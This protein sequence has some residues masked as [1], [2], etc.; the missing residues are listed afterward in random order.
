MR[1]TLNTSYRTSYRRPIGMRTV[2]KERGDLVFSMEYFKSYIREIAEFE[3]ST[4]VL[5]DFIMSAQNRI[6]TWGNFC[7]SV[8]R[9]VTSYER[10]DRFA[11][12]PFGPVQEIHSVEMQNADGTKRELVKDKDYIQTDQ[13]G[14]VRIELTSFNFNVS[15]GLNDDY[16]LIV[17]YSAGYTPDHP[18]QDFIR[19]A[20]ARL[21]SDLYMQRMGKSDG[22]RTDV[23]T[24]KQMIESVSL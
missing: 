8:E 19:P 15:T 14:L 22:S 9:L 10:V 13:N 2:I 16:G 4:G 5:N 7:P 17:D 11:P 21:A 20:V 23:S 1:R 3:G 12:L 24:I 6:K 18:A